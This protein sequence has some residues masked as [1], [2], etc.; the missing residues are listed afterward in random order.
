VSPRG[1]IDV[2]SSGFYHRHPA[3][4]YLPPPPGDDADG[5]LSDVS[6]SKD[7]DDD[8]TENAENTHDWADTSVEVAEETPRADA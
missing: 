8:D 7:G 1:A 2:P 6:E 5:W 3:H 4:R